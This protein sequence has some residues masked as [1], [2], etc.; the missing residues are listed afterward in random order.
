MIDWEQS[1]TKKTKVVSM[2]EYRVLYFFLLPGSAKQ[3]VEISCEI[4]IPFEQERNAF[5]SIVNVYWTKLTRIRDHLTIYCG[6]KDLLA[7]ILQVYSFRWCATSRSGF[8]SVCPSL[9]PSS[10]GIS[11]YFDFRPPP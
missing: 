11:L 1:N 10:K 4:L 8:V 6:M 2:H 3:E 5:L 7:E 9:H